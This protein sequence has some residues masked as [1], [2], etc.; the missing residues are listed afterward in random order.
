MVDDDEEDATP[1]TMMAHGNKGMCLECHGHVSKTCSSQKT[2][3]IWD[4]NERQLTK[5]MCLG[6]RRCVFCS[7]WSNR[8][9]TPLVAA[10][11]RHHVDNADTTTRHSTWK[12]QWSPTWLSWFSLRAAAMMLSSACHTAVSKADPVA[13]LQSKASMADS[14]HRHH[15]GTAA[16]QNP[17]QYSTAHQF[18]P[19]SQRAS[20]STSHGVLC[21]KAR[22]AWRDLFK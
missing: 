15:Q 12:L 16:Q 11:R 21:S 19:Q 1:H 22:S 17:T 8:A 4:A 10:S 5:H 2:V 6:F 20:P 7:P 3:K 13:L 9:Q 14:R 18:E